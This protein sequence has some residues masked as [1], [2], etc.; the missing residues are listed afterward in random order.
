MTTETQTKPIEI[1][2]AKEL[3]NQSEEMKVAALALKVT[4]AES[5]QYADGMLGSFR[6]L[7]K[8][9]EAA[10]KPTIDAAKQTVAK[11]KEG[12][13]TA[14]AFQSTH[15]QPLLDGEIDIK[16]K[17]LYWKQQETERIRKEQDEL[18]KKVR[19]EQEDA[20]LKRAAEAEKR[21]DTKAAERIISAPIA[22]APNI[23]RSLPKTASFSSREHWD[24]R[25]IDPALIPREFLEIDETRIR[26]VVTAM[27]G[28]TKIP[29]VEVFRNDIPAGR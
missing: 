6:A 22:P 27:K 19:A 21:G 7:R 28:T 16:N 29:G 5:F 13:E 15:T 11:A 20:K 2:G 1:P 14:Q 12:L 24:F 10:F 17:M 26:R 23:A 9:I 4:D 18:D 3:M 8:K 25:I